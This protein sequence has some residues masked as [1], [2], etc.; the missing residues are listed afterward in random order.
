MMQT[1]TSI[2]DAFVHQPTGCQSKALYM[3]EEFLE[4][5]QQCKAFVL[6]GSAGTGKTSL[7]QAV[8]KYLEKNNIQYVLLAPTAK[9]AKVLSKRTDD[10]ADTIHSAIYKPEELA[11]GT[12]KFNYESN[13]SQIRTVFVVDEASMLPAERQQQDDFL[14]PNPI[15]VDLMRFIK[16]GNTHNQVIFIGDT[17]QLPPVDEKT[18]VARLL[19]EKFEIDTKQ[20]TLKE[21]KRQASGSPILDLAIDIK[22]R[23]DTNYSLS[24]IPLKRLKNEDYGLNFFIQNFDR[25]NLQNIICI[26]Q[27]NEKVMDLN[28]KI[29]RRLYLDGQTLSKGDVVMAHRSWAGKEQ[30][31]S[32]G[33]MGIV[34]EVGYKT[35]ERCSLRFMNAT[36]D[37]DGVIIH[38][39]VLIDTLISPK[40]DIDKEKLKDLKHDRMTK[41]PTYRAS[42]KPSDDEYMGA[43][44]LRYGYAITCHKAQGSEWKKVLIE[45]QFH[46]GNHRWL[47]TAVTRASKEVWSWWY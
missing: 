9:A 41:N 39:K 34:L 25:D 14:T 11:D 17:Y 47:Y 44:H 40:G 29:R 42:E 5:P 10:F 24:R 1:T 45:P 43:I 3:I 6:R 26:T 21:V 19:S 37:F 20:T 8:V 2:F 22:H 46:L 32:K 23:H 33:D 35:D 30:S 28:H 7:M 36:I 31:I 12:I 27:S 15:L 38:T 16:E 13:N 18:S 4:K